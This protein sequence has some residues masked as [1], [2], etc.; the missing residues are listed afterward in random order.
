MKTKTKQKIL[1]IFAMCILI[2]GSSHLMAQNSSASTQTV[3]IGVEPYTLEDPITGVPTANYSYQWSI[4]PI[5]GALG[6]GAF[7]GGTSTG[8]SVN[9]DWTVQGTYTVSLVATDNVTGCEDS[10]IDVFKH[11]IWRVN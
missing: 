1:K 6:G 2:L 11:C 5:T 7:V 8:F 3:C 4:T 9:I 10:P